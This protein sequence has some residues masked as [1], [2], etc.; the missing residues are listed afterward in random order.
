MDLQKGIQGDEKLETL[1]QIYTVLTYAP[2]I[3][4]LPNPAFKHPSQTISNNGTMIT[5]SNNYNTNFMMLYPSIE[6][7][8]KYGMKTKTVS[9]K[10]TKFTSWIAVG[11]CH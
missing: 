10:I 6:G 5:Q 9:I 8:K 4:Y 11:I 2:K 3:I 7:T 1:L